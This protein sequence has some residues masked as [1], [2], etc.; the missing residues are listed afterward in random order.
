MFSVHSQTDSG[1]DRTHP[2]DQSRGNVVGTKQSCTFSIGR[3][4]I[5]IKPSIPCLFLPIPTL[6][7][8]KC[9]CDEPKLGIKYKIAFKFKKITINYYCTKQIQD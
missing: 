1:Q 8:L 5:T 6:K 2:Y 3:R 9:G 4:Q 7:Q